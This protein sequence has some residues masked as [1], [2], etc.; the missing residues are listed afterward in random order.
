MQDIRNAPSYREAYEGGLRKRARIVKNLDALRQWLE[1]EGP[2]E[3]LEKEAQDV[4]PPSK[5]KGSR[6]RTGGGHARKKAKSEYFW[7]H[8]L[9]MKSI[10]ELPK[11]NSFTRKLINKPSLQMLF[12]D[13]PLL[14]DT[15]A[16]PTGT[17]ADM[18]NAL[19]F[20]AAVN[21]MLSVNERNTQ[22]S[23]LLV[24][25]HLFFFLTAHPNWAE[26]RSSRKRMPRL[27]ERKCEDL[28]DTYLG[29]VDHMSVSVLPRH[30]FLGQISKWI[31][32]GSRYAFLASHLSLG[33]LVLLQHLLTP[34]AMQGCTK[35]NEYGAVQGVPVSEYALQH[36]RE[37]G[38]VQKAE[39]ADSMM[40]ALLWEM[41]GQ[42]QG[43]AAPTQAARFPGFD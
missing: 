31:K 15:A 24:L 39:R 43:M 13:I 10:G 36:L 38:L 25:L 17:S 3:G 19:R 23:L 1:E 28:Y 18:R 2:E 35:G 33:C 42:F 29:L 21:L 14:S 40:H 34:A 12:A 32:L 11:L 6:R 26:Q 41:M 20:N 37:I 30:K 5:P 22:N 16:A 7:D 9:Q 4:V 27:N 8:F